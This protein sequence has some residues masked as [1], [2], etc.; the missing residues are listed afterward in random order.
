M[1]RQHPYLSSKA[2]GTATRK[3][4][5]TKPNDCSLCLAMISPSLQLGLREAMRFLAGWKVH[6]SRLLCSPSTRHR[7]HSGP[8][9][10]CLVVF[11]QLSELE[12]LLRLESLTVEC[13]LM[14]YALIS[15]TQRVFLTALLTLVLNN[16]ICLKCTFLLNTFSLSSV[17]TVRC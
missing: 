5:A 9:L 16:K 3:T 12:K 11:F 14:R 8:G 15:Q 13:I 1:C 4:I 17:M 6:V 10:F 2:F 7:Q